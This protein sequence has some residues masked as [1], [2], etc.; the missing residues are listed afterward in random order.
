ML[1]EE[2]RKIALPPL[3]TTHLVALAW[4]HD[5]SSM[6]LSVLNESPLPAAKYPQA[7]SD[8]KDQ[9]KSSELIHSWAKILPN[10]G[11]V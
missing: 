7:D 1:F 4:L 8:S 6:P 9:T 2:D 10:P 3:N 11:G 5:R